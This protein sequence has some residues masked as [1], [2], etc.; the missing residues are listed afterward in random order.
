VGHRLILGY[1]FGLADGSQ[2]QAF[3]IA[4]S[5][6]GSLDGPWSL[7]GRPSISQFGDTFENYEFLQIDGRWRLVATTNTLDRPYFASL[8]GA[9]TDPR[10]WLRWTGGRVLD[11]PAEPWNTAP[12]LSGVTHEVANAIYLCDARALDGHYYVF[13]MGSTELTEFGGWGHAKIGIARSTDLV[14]WEVP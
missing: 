11:I 7:V 13:S 9:P 2:K 14:H 1:K 6:S 5:P 12:G 3:E 10:S 4:S 8:A